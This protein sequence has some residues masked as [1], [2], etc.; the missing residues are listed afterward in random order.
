MEE[1]TDRL[2]VAGLQAAV[3]TISPAAVPEPEAS[4]TK[5]QPS[6]PLIAKC[7]RATQTPLPGGLGAPGG[8]L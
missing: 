7:Q 6:G 2:T 3:T 1:R 4:G 8:S 5:R